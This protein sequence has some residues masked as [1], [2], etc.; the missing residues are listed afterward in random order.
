MLA[1][2]MAGNG[3]SDG[4]FLTASYSL[5]VHFEPLK[6]LQ[7]KCVYLNCS[8]IKYTILYNK[9]T[10]SLSIKLLNPYILIPAIVSQQLSKSSMLY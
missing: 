7:A 6:W 9:M 1:E 8:T 10:I 2:V 4:L 3:G 5:L